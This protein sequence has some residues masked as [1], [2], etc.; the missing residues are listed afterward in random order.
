MI[1]AYNITLYSFFLGLKPHLF[2]KCLLNEHAQKQ[3]KLPPVYNTQNEG[4]GHMPKFR[5][6]VMFDGV[7][8]TSTNTFQQRKMAEMDVSR[9]AY[10][11]ITQKFKS[12]ALQFIREV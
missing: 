8:Y 11:T 3:R 9:I 5:S 4:F 10:I 2:Y 7:S 12:D 6:T 1:I